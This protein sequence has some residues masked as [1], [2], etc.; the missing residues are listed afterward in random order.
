MYLKIRKIDEI[1]KQMTLLS[2]HDADIRNVWKSKSSKN[3]LPTTVEEDLEQISSNAP[4]LVLLSS[5]IMHKS[6]HAKDHPF[7]YYSAETV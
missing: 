7:S 2:I 5:I 3:H 6:I 1:L 4:I